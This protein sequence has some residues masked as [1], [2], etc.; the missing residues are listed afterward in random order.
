MKNLLRITALCA[1]GLILAEPAA[2]ARSNCG[3]GPPCSTE[4]TVKGVS[5]IPDPNEFNLRGDLFSSNFTDL[6]VRNGAQQVNL[7]FNVN[8]GFG[9]TSTLFV[10]KNGIISF[11]APIAA[12]QAITP[13]SSLAANATGGGSVLASLGAP[14]IAPYFADLEP[15]GGSG[16]TRLNIGDVTVQFG[17]ADPYANTFNPT[18]GTYG[19]DRADLRQAVRITWYGLDATGNG[20]PGSSSATTGLPVYAQLLISADDNGLSNFEF[21]YGPPNQPGQADYGS[22]AGFALGNTV[23]EF[24]GPY[25]QG[26]P[27]FFEFN[28]GVYIGQGGTTVNPAVPEPAT[29]AQLIMGFGAVGYAMRRRRMRSGARLALA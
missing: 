1:G 20:V 13:L 12:G 25:V 2:A 27:T 14:V 10:H 7:G 8:F 15:G 24:N 3:N 28:D 21:R 16:D 23:L 17:Q 29:W 26:I 11:G 5:I 18:T 4:G 19:Y 22:V 9:L 6:A